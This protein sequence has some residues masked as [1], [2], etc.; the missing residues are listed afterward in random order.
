MKLT[1]I[2]PAYNEEKSIGDVIR[3]I[4]ANIP[5][6][7][8]LKIVV[9]D[10]NSIDKTAHNAEQAGALVIS[11]YK[12]RGVGAAFQSGL[13]KALELNTDVLV[14][15]D[16]DGQFSPKEITKLITPII[17]NEADFVVGDRFT[18]TEENY[19]KPMHMPYVKYWGNKQMSKLIS[20]LVRQRFADVSCGFR[21]YSKEAMLMLNLSGKFTYTQESFLDLSVKGLR[22]KS[23]P[24]SVQYFPNRKSKVA[25]NVIKYMLRTLKIIIRTFRD[26]KPMLFFGILGILPLLIGLLA[27]VFILVHYIINRSFTPYKVVGFGGV[28]FISLAFLLFMVGLFSDMFVRIRLNQEDIMYFIKKM[29]Y[30]K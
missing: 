21:A 13:K 15:I 7:T 29:I 20:V 10:D 6:I 2:I 12:N 11:H 22:I 1:I 18:D 24:V 27:S 28:F 8:T 3:N 17:N 19:R 26:Y 14:N 16:A 30:K 23:I 9:V 5:N 4:P 25:G